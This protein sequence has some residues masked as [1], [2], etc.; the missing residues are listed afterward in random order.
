[1]LCQG[2]IRHQQG[3]TTPKNLQKTI[4]EYLPPLLLS[5]ELSQRFDM[6]DLWGKR[7]I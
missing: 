7:D 1:M 4:S 5:Q 6:I 3:I 2:E